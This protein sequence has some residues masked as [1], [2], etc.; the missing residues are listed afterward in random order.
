[1]TEVERQQVTALGKTL[2]AERRDGCADRVTDDGLSAFLR[3][4]SA[5]AGSAARLPAVQRAIGWLVGYDGMTLAERDQALAA[6]IEELRSL[7]QASRNTPE[8]PPPPAPEQPAAPRRTAPRQARNRAAQM[9]KHSLAELDLDARLEQIA[10]A[11]LRLVSGFR[12]L[13]VVTIRDLLYHFPRRY[14]DVSRRRSISELQVGAEETVI[15]EVTDVRT[16]GTGPK[17]RVRVEVSD[18]TGS[19]EAIFFNQRWIAQQI[20]VGQ[21]IALSGKVTVFGGKRQFSSP[22]WER[23]TPDP[24]ALLHTGRLVPIHPLTQGLHENQARRFIKQVIDTITPRVPDHLPPHRREQAR[25]LPLG[26]ALAQIHFPA[27]REQLDAARRRLGF[28]EFLF[29]Q[30]GV[31]QRKRLWQQE[32]GLP[33]TIDTQVHAEL[34]QRLPFQLTTA[35]HR[36]ISEIFA[37]LQRPSPMARLLQ[38]DVGSGKTVVAAAAL[39]QAVA[40]GF[41]GALMAPTEILAEQHAK[42]LKQLLSRVR[43]PRKTAMAAGEVYQQADWRAL[44]DPDDAA[45]LA[46]IVAILGMTPEEDMGGQGVRVALLTGSLGTRERRR[47]LEGIA[48]GEIDLVVG[49]HALITETVQFAQ[50][51]LVVV[52]EQHRFG[53]EQRLRLKNKGCNPHM[54]VMTATPIPR[55]LTLTIYGDLDV[56]VLDE[57]PPGRQEIRTRRISRS[58]REKAYRHIRKQVAEGRQVYVICPL[59][60]ESEKLELPSAEEMYER[61][62]RE[63]FPDLRV[64]LLHGKMPAREKDEVM[65]AF[66]DHQYDILVATAVIEVGIDVPN[67]T[68]IVIEGAE[69]FG[70]A[71]LHQFRGRVGRGNHQSYCIL[72]SDSDNQQSRERLAALEQTTDGFKLAEIDLQLRGPGEFFG[73]R[74]SGTPDL[75]MAQQGDTRLLV[76]ARRL[77]EA[78]LNDDPELARPE[79]HLLRQ[80]VA[81]FWS[82][83]LQAG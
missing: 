39:L 63:V 27:N 57:R 66:R 6:A 76:E 83:A 15:G 58:E 41:Q 67:A 79:H 51:G 68:T 75:K 30:I 77:A 36:A 70:L 40:N 32:M 5:A 46:E 31:L 50:L 42:N 38:G 24:D 44:L 14:D 81:A 20:K 8:T 45:K 53:V 4:W 71:Q 54:L 1:M 33:F 3:Q 62:Q 55:T 7:F 23:Y 29:I 19:I 37:D 78:I 16:I 28:D 43:V 17:L 2:A 61:L 26:E 65:R 18:E 72:I 22:R 25:L 13:G 80:K 9:P 35:Q 49:T 59:V 34:Q 64:A 56:S 11:D 69:R 82:E 48:R 52:D 21:T 73:T 60:E 47:V 74:Q 10:H 12:R